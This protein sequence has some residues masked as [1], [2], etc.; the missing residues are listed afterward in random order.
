MRENDP[1]GTADRVV[2]AAIR[3]FASEATSHVTLKRIALEAGLPSEEVT[4][5]WSSTAELLNA[6]TERLTDELAAAGTC[7]QVPTRGGELSERQAEL[8]DQAVQLLAR[9]RLDQIEPWLPEGRFPILNQLIDQFVADGADL[10]T[11]RYRAFQL[12][13][14]EFGARLFAPS[15]LVAVGL[16]DE[17]PAQV[18]AEIDS[19]Q[20]LVAIRA[21]HPA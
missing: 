14:V 18:R 19:L 11:A 3:V 2:A 6:A 16:H 10:R 4:S 17:T 20:D 21:V 13:V 9:A 8:L 12:L 15:L 7:A 5:R 1:A